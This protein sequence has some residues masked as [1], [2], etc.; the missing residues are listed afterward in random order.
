VLGG[1]VMKSA[2]LFLDKIRSVVRENC[3]LVPSDRTAIVLASLG[4]DVGLI[5]AAE[6]WRHR[7]ECK[8]T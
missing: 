7:L 5:G 3:R 6:V 2:D 1:S 8:G 4:K